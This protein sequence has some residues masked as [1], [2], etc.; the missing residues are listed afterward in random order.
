MNFPFSGLYYTLFPRNVAW[1][2]C[3]ELPAHAC[4][5]GSAGPQRHRPRAAPLHTC[6]LHL[7]LFPLLVACDWVTAKLGRGG[8]GTSCCNV[9][10]Y[11]S[12]CGWQAL[13]WV[14]QFKE[15]CRTVSA[16]VFLVSLSAKINL[17][18]STEITK[19]FFFYLKAC[20][21]K[22]EH[23]KNLLYCNNRACFCLFLSAQQSTT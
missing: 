3:A 5:P 22:R 6:D 20:V 9:E 23:L 2:T 11:G 12:L 14:G 21:A 4:G 18:A 8:E 7:A 10:A 1:T 16:E 15:T 19:R 17:F 13:P